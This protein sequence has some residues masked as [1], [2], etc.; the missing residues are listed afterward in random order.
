MTELFADIKIMDKT[1]KKQDI[2]I[3]MKELYRMNT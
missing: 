3:K 2:K 1:K